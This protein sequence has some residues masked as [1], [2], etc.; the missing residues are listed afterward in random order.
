MKKQKRIIKDENLNEIHRE[1]NCYI[2]GENGDLIICSGCLPK[3][4]TVG[5]FRK[6]ISVYND[7]LVIAKQ[8]NWIKESEKKT[9]LEKARE[10]NPS[11][12]AVR[13]SNCPLMGEQRMRYEKAIKELQEKS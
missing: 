2:C 13:H 10:Y 9:A 8:N 12:S 6:T 1:N 11:C 4:V 5:E 7:S 3:K